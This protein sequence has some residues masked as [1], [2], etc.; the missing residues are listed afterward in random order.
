MVILKGK[1]FE[2]DILVFPN[3]ESIVSSLISLGYPFEIA[4][5][6]D[7]ESKPEKEESAC[8]CILDEGMCLIRLFDR[9]DSVEGISCLCHE[10]YYAVCRIMYRAGVKLRDEELIGRM[11][12]N[13]MKQFLLFISNGER[14][15]NDKRKKTHS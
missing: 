3:G 5:K 7:E 10:L 4:K 1:L 13:Y 9:A 12:Q 14:S 2:Y 15:K 6:M 11:M 8:N